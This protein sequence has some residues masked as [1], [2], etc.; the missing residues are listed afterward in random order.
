M[1]KQGENKEFVRYVE[2][3]IIA[4]LSIFAQ[5]NKEKVEEQDLPFKGEF[6]F[7]DKEKDRRSASAFLILLLDCIERWATRVEPYSSDYKGPSEFTKTFQSLVQRRVL[8]PSQCK[9]SNPLM[10]L[11]L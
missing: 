8:F 5:H 9:I 11:G 2:K 10:D 1:G 3:K 4:R 6:I 7:S